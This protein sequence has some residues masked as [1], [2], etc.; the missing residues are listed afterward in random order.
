MASNQSWHHELDALAGARHQLPENS[1]SMAPNKNRVFRA[2]GWIFFGLAALSGVAHIGQKALTGSESE[3]YYSGTMISWTYGAAFIAIGATA[4]IA[5]GAWVFR[6]ITH[7]R[8]GK[9]R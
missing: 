4:V 5:L 2:I 1:E 3:H 8:N 9:E 7:R 6:L